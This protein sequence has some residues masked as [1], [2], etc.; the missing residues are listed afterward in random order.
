MMK[1]NAGYR[2][3]LVQA[4][5]FAQPMSGDAKGRIANNAKLTTGLT[6]HAQPARQLTCPTRGAYQ[7]HAING[8]VISRNHARYVME[9]TMKTYA[10]INAQTV[11]AA[12]WKT[13]AMRMSVA[14]AADTTKK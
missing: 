14:S 5:E 4:A 13:C 7:Q 8:Y 11:E 12:T 6:S 9:I 1:D 2:D 3:R 10:I